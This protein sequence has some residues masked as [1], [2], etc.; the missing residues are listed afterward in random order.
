MEPSTGTRSST[1]LSWSLQQV[2]SLRRRVSAGS[3]S[4]LALA[5]R[6][7]TF[8]RHSGANWRLPITSRKS[9]TIPLL[10][11]SGED[12]PT[13]DWTVPRSGRLKP[14]ATRFSHRALITGLPG[15]SVS[16]RTLNLSAKS[17]PVDLASPARHAPAG[18]SR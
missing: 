17:P 18:T 6:E 4:A 9:S 15:W 13:G 3:S 16:M 11:G 2:S 8:A 10:S 5:S 1:S 14:A 12:E 7:R